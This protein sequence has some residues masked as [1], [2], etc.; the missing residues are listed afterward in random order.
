[1]VRSVMLSA[2]LTMGLTTFASAAF[3]PNAIGNSEGLVIQVAEGCGPGLWRGPGGR[4]H[5]F[6]VGRACPEDTTSDPK[7]NAAGRIE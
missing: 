2:V 4:C 7:A 3:V 1:M 5:P 6:A